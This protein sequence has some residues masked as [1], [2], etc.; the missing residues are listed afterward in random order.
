MTKPED[1]V[2]GTIGGPYKHCA[3]RLKDLPELDY[4]ITD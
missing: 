2:S 4:R 1:P 3:I